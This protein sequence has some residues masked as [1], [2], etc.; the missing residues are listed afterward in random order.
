MKDMYPILIFS[1]GKTFMKEYPDEILI[2]Q[3][4]DGD[5]KAFGV[6]VDRYK[7]AIHKL[8][9]RKLGDFHDAE[10]V[11]Q[12]AF[13][14]AHQKLSTLK[15]KT[16]FA[17]WLYAIAMN[18]C[19]MLLRRRGHRKAEMI[20]LDELGSEKV[21]RISLFRHKNSSGRTI[22]DEAMDM[23][24]K[25]DGMT[26]R[27]YYMDGMSCAEIGETIGVSVNA[28]RDRLY[29]A[30]KRLKKEIYKMTK[31]PITPK[32]P[33]DDFALISMKSNEIESVVFDD[34]HRKYLNDLSGQPI[35]KLFDSTIGILIDR[36]STLP[37]I[38]GIMVYDSVAL[39]WA[40]EYSSMDF[41]VL[42]DTIPSPSV[43]LKAYE[44][45]GPPLCLNS[46][47]A[48]KDKVIHDEFDIH[49]EKSDFNHWNIRTALFLTLETSRSASAWIEQVVNSE[50]VKI[51]GW[52]TPSS[53]Q[54]GLIL[55]D[56]KG[57][58]KSLQDR[59]IPM[60]DSVRQFLIRNAIEP[61]MHGYEGWPIE[62]AMKSVR[63]GNDLWSPHL[64]W[65]L[66][67]NLAYICLIYNG[68]YYPGD[69]NLQRHLSLCSTLPENCIQRFRNIM[70][71]PNNEQTF[72]DWLELAKEVVMM[73]GEVP[74][75]EQVKVVTT[76]GGVL[77][78]EQVRIALQEF[79]WFS[80]WDG[81]L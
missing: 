9:Y 66:I 4:L 49:F 64:F 18:Y 14:R 35:P 71:N 28:V 61:I 63:R 51:D 81:R 65:V 42:F 13:L 46:E 52:P 57:V 50:N 39:G 38:L 78:E 8:T 54:N 31:K 73:V 62:D 23:L 47:Q 7:D 6:L 20:S 69:N 11:A 15:D 2:Q 22:L 72:K 17:S 58:L 75:E 53:L 48:T 70:S 26:L 74:Y 40:D 10:D 30:R 5:E 59:L 68:R 44:G 80:E 41:Y 55:F 56:P 77:H 1:I 12:E 60:P 36:L 16:K 32:I 79:K 27:L 24:P 76:V 67:K 37:G 34:S 19:R 21:S 45:F 43:R 33:E 25:L 3:T 29:W